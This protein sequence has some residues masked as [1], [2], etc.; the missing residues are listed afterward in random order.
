M[1]AGLRWLLYLSCP[2]NFITLSRQYQGVTSVWSGVVVEYLNTAV[3]ALQVVSSS[4]K[5]D[6]YRMTPN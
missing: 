2:S 4:S 3:P 1:K 6:V 5:A